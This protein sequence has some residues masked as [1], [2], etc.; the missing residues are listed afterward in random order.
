[1]PVWRRRGSCS[2]GP[3]NTFFSGSEWLNQGSDRGGEM[4]EFER[5]LEGGISEID[6]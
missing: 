1:M 5:H 2:E 3:V 6:E 4:D